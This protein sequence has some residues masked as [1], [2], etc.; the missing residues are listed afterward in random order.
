[1]D[2]LVSAKV[3]F[4]LRKEDLKLTSFVTILRK[5]RNLKVSPAFSC[6]FSSHPKHQEGH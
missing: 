2:D 5:V 6:A 1:M 3:F 4:S